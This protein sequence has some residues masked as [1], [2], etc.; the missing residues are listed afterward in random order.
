MCNA[1]FISLFDLLLGHSD[2]DLVNFVWAT[3][4]HSIFKFDMVTHG[5]P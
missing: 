5:N 3:I 2:L 4:S 1:R